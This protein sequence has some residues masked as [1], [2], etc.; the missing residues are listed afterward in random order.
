[1]S[2]IAPPGQGRRYRRD[3]RAHHRT[4]AGD[5]AGARSRWGARAART[6]APKK[7][8]PAKKTAVAKKKPSRRRRRWRRTQRRRSRVRR[9][10]S[11]SGASCRARVR[12]R[13][14]TC[15]VEHENKNRIRQ[16]VTAVFSTAPSTPRTRDAACDGVRCRGARRTLRRLHTRRV[17]SPS[18]NGVLVLRRVALENGLRRQRVVGDDDVHRTLDHV[19]DLT[20]GVA[21]RI[22]AHAASFGQ[23]V[24]DEH[25]RPFACR[26]SLQP[27]LRPEVA[28]SGSYRSCQDR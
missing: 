25:D 20:S 17:R 7:P 4:R 27:R 22:A 15:A 28:A 11:L 3:V 24:R 9:R 18:G 6:P 5:Q 26:R 10:R 23:Q 8:T 21:R 16:L 13:V 19:G 1:M 14:R 12:V 2:G